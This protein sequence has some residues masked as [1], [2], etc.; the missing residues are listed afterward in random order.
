MKRPVGKASICSTSAYSEGGRQGHMRSTVKQTAAASILPA[1]DR[2]SGVPLYLQLAAAM[3]QRIHR[4]DLAPGSKIPSLGDLQ[5]E[6]GVAR[7][8]VRQ[9]MDRL[10]REG[11]ISRHKGK[12]TFVKSNGGDRHW[13]HL[14]T[15]WESL[16]ASIRDNQPTQIPI[17]DPPPLPS[18][19]E[20]DARTAAEYVFLRSV[21][22]RDGDPYALVNVH[23]AKDIYD[24]DPETFQTHAAL[25]TLA[26]MKGV[27]VIK[28][29]QILLI[30]AADP[31][32][33]NML[34]IPL[35][36]PTAEAHWTVVDE[37]NRAIYVA[38]VTYRGDCV[39]LM[40]DFL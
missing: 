24:R 6:F 17:D 7:V 29:R 9:A 26:D 30:G 16:L 25:P 28:A 32:T 37:K 34:R 33:A 36:T 3:R 21:Q 18:L 22:A 19:G 15:Q 14:A 4:G 35:N 13:L 40:I 39:K 11:L 2:E 12:G 38:Q 5:T 10:E 20:C 31:Y 8:T 27:T 1:T 23:L